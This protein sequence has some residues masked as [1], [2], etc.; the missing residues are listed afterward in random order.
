MIKSPLLTN[1]VTS[2]VS[3]LTGDSLAQYVEMKT[4]TSKDYDI[5]RTGCAIM[6][7]TFLFTPLFAIWFRRLDL[8][9]PGNGFQ[10][11]IKKVCINQAVVT[12]PINAGFLAYTT[13]IEQLL[14]NSTNN[15]VFDS[16]I[17]Q[18]RIQTQLVEDLPEVFT[19]SCM[20]WFPVNTL[21]FLFVSPTFRV[22]PT[23]FA[24]TGWSVYLS[25]TAHKRS[26]SI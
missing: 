18:H 26:I 9:I 11:V 20:L 16:T 25:L 2:G 17:I 10:Q 1:M 22:L 14:G 8:M 24:S 23:I 13:A 4:S 6:W 21:N 15:E 3:M 12:I 5:V 19:R 7:N